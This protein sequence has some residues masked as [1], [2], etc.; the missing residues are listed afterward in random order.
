MLS[1]LDGK[2]PL[3]IEKESNVN[4]PVSSSSLTFQDF[5]GGVIPCKWPFRK[6]VCLGKI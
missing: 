6:K 5:I 2:S 1:V 4:F 3:F